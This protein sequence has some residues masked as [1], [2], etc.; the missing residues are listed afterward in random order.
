MPHLGQPAVRER[1]LQ[2]AAEHID[3]LAGGRA[4]AV[5][6][7]GGQD[8]GAVPEGAVG[9]GVG[10]RGLDLLLTA[11]APVAV[12][13]VLGHLGLEVVGDVLDQPGA[14]PPGARE[15][16]ATGGAGGESVRR[17]AVDVLGPGTCGTRV[18]DHC[19]TLL[20][21]GRR[22]GLG[23]R[24]DGSG[25]RVGTARGAGRA[26]GGAE[27]E[28]EEDDGGPVT[29]EDRVGLVRRQRAGT[30]RGDEGGIE[31]PVHG[32]HARD[33]RQP[34]RKRKPTSGG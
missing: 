9:Q 31:N 30:E 8:D 25:R 34:A 6:Q 15:P 4:Q 16:P 10:N 14:G 1:E 2:V 19:T 11:R 22:R 12:D 33:S 3:D 23:V 32:R 29:R 7:P 13:R 20:P 18:A 17:V 5:V 26:D 24:R 27:L 21:P 28:E